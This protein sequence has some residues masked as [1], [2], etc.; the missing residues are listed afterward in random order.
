MKYI[1]PNMLGGSKN[2]RF[3]SGGWGG[4]GGDNNEDDKEENEFGPILVGW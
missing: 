1:C 3:S 2:G 4:D